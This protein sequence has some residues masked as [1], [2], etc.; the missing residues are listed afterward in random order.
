MS[1]QKNNNIMIEADGLTKLYGS[2]K[3]VEDITFSCRQGE[4][5]GFLGPNGAGKTT[6]MRIL[7]GYMPPNAGA[8]FI[9]GYNTL[10]ESIQARQHLGYM[11]ETVPLYQEMSV[12]SYL[13]FVGRLRNVDNLWE[14][15]DDV[16]EAVDLLDRAE[17]H[18]G[19][20]SKGMRQRVGLAQA[21]IHDP[22]VLI[23]DEPTIGLDPAQ[24]REVRRLI[25]ELGK[26]HTILLSTH[27]LTE[28]EQICNRV[29]M[30]ING[31]IWADMPLK[32][33]TGQDGSTLLTL[34]LAQPAA[35]TDATLGQLPGVLQVNQTQPRE[36][37]LLIDGREATRIN[38]ASTAV[39]AG[40]GLLELSA[41]RISL[42][43]LFL[44]KMNEAELAR[45]AEA[46]E[47]EELM[48]EE[49]EEMLAAGL[50]NAELEEE[51]E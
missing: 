23:L 37:Q 33:I 11:P 46:A 2:V 29:I 45:A 28:V 38:V 49:K 3:A 24:I 43:T 34:K 39:N 16:M 47:E 41:V 32:E 14:K 21:L 4:I 7:T 31:R 1:D 20:L 22:D 48:A 8:A 15:V 44:D 5:V 9:A 25:V 6:T 42:E 30:I 26:K 19:K 50:A 51:E 27:I 13:A 10:S 18:I 17:T 36:Y 40:W 35:D 12:E